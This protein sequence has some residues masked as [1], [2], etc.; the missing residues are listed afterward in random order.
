MRLR[1]AFA[2]TLIAAALAMT[3]CT[4]TAASTS[5][6]A[7]PTAATTANAT[8]S[9]GDAT[10]LA[11]G[12]L[13]TAADVEKIS[14]LK[15]IRIVP[16]DPS[17]GAGGDINLATSEGKLVVMGNFGDGARFDSEKVTPNYRKAIPGLGDAAFVG[18]S[19]DIMPTLYIVGFKK[20]DHTA[21]LTTFFKGT[22]VKST[23]LSV[24]QL[25]RLAAI[26]ASRW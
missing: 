16:Y 17:K 5:G 2:A 9:A 14:G 10:T 20:G 8:E 19:K 4:G 12:S 1:I 3:A 15:G 22:N 13:L 18:P 24:Q 7:A 21:L 6:P 26:V 23:M 25:K 11:V